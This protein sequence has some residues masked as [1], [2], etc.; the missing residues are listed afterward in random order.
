MTR[1]PGLLGESFYNLL[2]RNSFYVNL[3]ISVKLEDGRRIVTFISRLMCTR[4]IEKLSKIHSNFERFASYCGQ[5]SNLVPG[6]LLLRHTHLEDN[7]KAR[8]QSFTVLRS[9][10]KDKDLDEKWLL[11]V[12]DQHQQP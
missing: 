10:N 4:L 6:C 8:R 1:I 12:K 2:K 7:M 11:Q 5:K 3:Q 9:V